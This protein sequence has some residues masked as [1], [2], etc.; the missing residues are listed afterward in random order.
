MSVLV[1]TSVWVDYLR[2]GD[3]RLAGL[4]EDDQVFCHPFIVGELACGSLEPRSEILERLG[5]LP[6]T[7]TVRNSEAIHFIE[8]H[9]LWGKGIGLIDVHILASAFLG[10]SE[11][12]TRYKRLNRIADDLG[13]AFR[14]G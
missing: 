5:L 4:L 14:E 11:L 6:E 10:K 13:I 8:Q 9:R 2:R 7:P 12:W 3:S 1:D